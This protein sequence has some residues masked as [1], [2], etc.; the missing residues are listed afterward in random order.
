MTNC[1]KPRCCINGEL[2]TGECECSPNA[3]E[4]VEG[5]ENTYLQLLEE[6]RLNGIAKT[7]AVYVSKILERFTGQ[8]RIY[9]LVNKMLAT[10]K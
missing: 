8:D 5:I 2:N 9:R 4:I 6:G 7:D 3:E 1:N 10:A